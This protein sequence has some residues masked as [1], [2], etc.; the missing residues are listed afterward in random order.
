MTVGG[1]GGGLI[2]TSKTA[3]SGIVCRDEF[4]TQF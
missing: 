2:T 1:G 3:I 4:L